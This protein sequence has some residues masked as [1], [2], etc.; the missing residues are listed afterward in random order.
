MELDLHFSRLIWHFCLPDRLFFSYPLT[1]L[2]ALKDLI[3]QSL[4]ILHS[5]VRQ[6]LKKKGFPAISVCW[7]SDRISKIHL[8]TLDK[9]GSVSQRLHHSKLKGQF[10]LIKLWI[11]MYILLLVHIQLQCTF[12]QTH[13][14]YIDTSFVPFMTSQWQCWIWTGWSLPNQDRVFSIVAWS[15]DDSYL[16]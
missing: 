9:D 15:Q 3:G 14:L 13:L 12:T 6:Y 2:S 8:C 1:S 10:L 16:I 7:V 11:F 5:C 4:S